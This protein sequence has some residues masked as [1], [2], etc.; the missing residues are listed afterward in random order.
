LT[1][2]GAYYFYGLL[3]AT[4]AFG[5]FVLLGIAYAL[6]AL[7]NDALI[8]AFLAV[9]GA[10]L[11]P[12]LAANGDGNHVV[13]FSYYAVVNAG[14]LAIARFKQWRSLN[15]LSFVF[16][17]GAGI[18]WGATSYNDQLFRSTEPFL[19]LFFCF[20][21][22][23]T[24]WFAQRQKADEG[25]IKH[26]ILDTL[27]LFANPLAAF[28]LQAAMLSESK[29]LVAYS[30]VALAVL[31]GI[32]SLLCDRRWRV[33]SVVTE[34]F[35][36]LASFFLAISIPLLFDPK[37]TP[38]IWAV[39]GAGLVWLGARRQR[40]WSHFWGMI[41]HFIASLAFMAEVSDTKLTGMRLFANHIYFST[42]IFSLA[43]LTGSYILYRS[44]AR[45]PKVA[46][47]LTIGLLCSG[48]LWWFGGGFSQVYLYLDH[49]AW[50]SSLLTFVALSCLLAE[51]A[52][53]ILNWPPL[54]FTLL[55]LL[56]FA[57]IGALDMGQGGIY[58]LAAGGWYAWPLV[59]A[60]HLLML[61]RW[62]DRKWLTLYHAG[63]VW[64]LT[65]VLTQIAVWQVDH[66]FAIGNWS[67]VA[68]LG[69]PTLVLLLI[70]P[71]NRRMPWPISTHYVR[72]VGVAATPI[73]LWLIAA[74]LSIGIDEAG[75]SAPFRYLPFF[76]PLDLVLVGLLLV[77]WLWAIQLGRATERGLHEL[78]AP[79]GWVLS[80]FAFL[81]ANAGVAR[82]VHHL[83]GAPF[84]FDALYDSATLQTAYA[85]FWGALALVL[86]FIAHHR[87]Q[88]GGW[89][90]VWYTGAAILG[91]TV[92]KLFIVDLAH[93]GTVARIISFMSVGLLI[94]VI[95][96]FW[97]VPPREQVA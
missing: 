62:A 84:T 57:A 16:T 38:A 43:A 31:Y 46:P 64:L 66:R 49:T 92:L 34:G 65:F 29:L 19:L 33:P 96:Y 81:A 90:G 4:L 40:L 45:W 71:A 32:L 3:P 68:L 83:T 70:G 51:L 21:L 58:P 39:L 72:Y 42:V 23:I 87:G 24:V 55:G 67:I 88:R 60:V 15:V 48:W 41:V 17:L 25:P 54:R 13:L 30:A 63:G 8:L 76:N 74:A 89:H 22:T 1:T 79:A 52:G 94:I 47:I 7:L 75:D 50:F 59:L 37:V 12:I 20:Y 26:G 18:G 91:L 85:I 93:T 97:P 6:M 44:R 77:L 69:V 14:I 2:F 61:W 10:F 86:M 27:L 56:P 5:I 53:A 36:F 95:A 9:V 80:L 82:A 78:S 35:I 28:V 73:A 11:A